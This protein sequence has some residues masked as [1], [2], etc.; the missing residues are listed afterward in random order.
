MD[1]EQ[2]FINQTLY[3]KAADVFKIDI[4]P[5]NEII[6]DCLFIV[7]TNALL[8]PY[9]TSSF[10]FEEIEKAYSKLIKTKQLIIPGQVA[11]E[12]AKNRPEK[13][14][15]LF[16][17]LNIIKGKIKNL[18]TGQYPLL[19][20][21]REYKEAVELENEI[22]ILQKKYSI[23]IE[24][25]LSQ[26][27]DWRWNDPVSSVY[28][29]LFSEDIIYE[30]DIDQDTIIKE[31]ERRNKF[32]IPPGFNDK[33]KGDF[34]VGDLLI[35]L[36]I[37]EVAKEQKKDVIFISGDEKND[38]FYRSESQSLYPR[39]ELVIEFKHATN[40]KS[41]HIIK[42]SQLLTEL[43]AD[44]KAV[45]EVEFTERN[46]N[47][48]FSEYRNF[49]LKAVELVY[50][51][52]QETES[53]KEIV[54]NNGFPDFLIKDSEKIEGVDVMTLRGGRN[55]I[56]LHRFQER[57]MRAYYEIKEGKCDIFKFVIVVPDRD[58][59]DSVNKYF[60]RFSDKYKN[61]FISIIAGTISDD[62]NFEQL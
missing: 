4:K 28:N 45:K 23:K 39:F 41:F 13:I 59:I 37:L 16:Q 29:R 5:I 8:I 60:D 6:G 31:L 44:E 48:G 21:L 1:K 42:L 32:S 24:E 61:E 2:I 11:R 47:I 55:I 56:S 43:G 35:W 38:W 51:W 14:K 3:P 58:A 26:I 7:D 20:T 25:I 46:V 57:Y 15:T 53:K 12:F 49:S 27:K 52:L 19:E 18:S 40:G 34:G 36:T 33:S 30:F 10:G 17:Q 62:G 22:R 54:V 9:T 50:K